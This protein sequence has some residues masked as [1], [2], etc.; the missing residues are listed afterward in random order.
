MSG[1]VLA[2]AL[3]ASLLGATNE[4]YADAHRAVAETGKPMLVM[5]G[6][7]WCGPCQRL[8]RQVL[9]KLRQRPIF[10]R[11]AFAMVDVD[12]E[13]K[14]A[15]KLTGGGPVPQLVMFRKGP[16][17]WFRRKLVGGQALETV[18]KFVEQGVKLDQVAKRGQSQ[19]D[20]EV[21]ETRSRGEQ[22]R[23]TPAS[24]KQA[25]KPSGTPAK[26]VSAQRAAR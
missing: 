24:G 18:E 8:K 25:D 15:R 26:E 9:P 21:A 13:S 17:G 16:N 10:K 11:I 22:V 1:C 3:Q 7:K 14:L 20:G 2:I 6:A 5:V 23:G 19:D 4:S 12:Q